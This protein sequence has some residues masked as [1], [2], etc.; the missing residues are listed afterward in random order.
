MHSRSYGNFSLNHPD[1]EELGEWK[2]VHET[3]RTK[4]GNAFIKILGN[5]KL[6]YEFGFLISSPTSPLLNRKENH[7]SSH[8]LMHRTFSTKIP[9]GMT[10][11]KHFEMATLK[12]ESQKWLQKER[13]KKLLLSK[14]LLPNQNLVI[15]EVKERLQSFNRARKPLTGSFM[16]LSSHHS[17]KNNSQDQR[18]PP[19][20]PHNTITCFHLHLEFYRYF[21]CNPVSL[22]II[23]WSTT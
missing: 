14:L 12:A 2:T 21:D 23:E 3:C 4:N 15:G 9:S 7:V 20:H 8:S 10:V 11:C 1:L 18:H 5:T 6:I 17:R 22:G 13:E 19:A 16:Q